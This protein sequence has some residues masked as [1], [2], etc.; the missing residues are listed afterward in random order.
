MDINDVKKVALFGAGTMGPGLA[1]V[2]AAAGYKVAMCDLSKEALDTALTVIRSNLNTFVERKLL[3]AEIADRA[4]KNI[5]PTQSLEDAGRDADVVIEAII[6]KKDAKRE[7][8]ER[9]NRVCPDRTV[10]MSNTSYLNIFDVMSQ[11]RQP[12]TVIAHWFAPPHIIPLVEVVRGPETSQAT[13]DFAVELLK[14]VDRVPAVMEK[15]VPGFCINRLLRIIGREVFFLLDNGYMSP[16]ELDLAVKASIIPRAMVLG[17][18]QR[19]DFTGLDLS[20]RNLENTEYLEPPIDNAPRSLLDRVNNGDLGVKTGRGFFDYGGR[21]LEDVLKE[22]DVA[23]LDV[24]NN[25]KHLMY[26]KI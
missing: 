20:A 3:S 15:F 14:K 9:L 11:E 4:Q 21:K 13:V 1:Q 19:Y 26:K 8:Y 22:R 23:L 16:E 12:N 7:L 6:E 17:V 5:A 10:F 25:S 24:F 18:V 2:F